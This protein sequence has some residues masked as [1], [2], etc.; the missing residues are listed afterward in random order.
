MIRRREQ[1]PVQHRELAIPNP[2]L[3]PQHLIPQWI[4]KFDIICPGV[5]QIWQ[6]HGDTRAGRH[7]PVR[8]EKFVEGLLE[9]SS[10][11]F[12][13]SEATARIIILSSYGTIVK[14]HGPKALATW[15]KSQGMSQQ[16]AAR[17]FDEPSLG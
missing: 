13:N 3:M 12:D 8:K 16:E 6:Y 11:M 15:R 9:R 5:F 4:E 10:K 2:I 1:T 14:H 17:F 7:N